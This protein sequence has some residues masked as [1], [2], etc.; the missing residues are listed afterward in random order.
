MH[1]SPESEGLQIVQIFPEFQESNSTSTS[2]SGLYV[3]ALPAAPARVSTEVWTT[4][5]MMFDGQIFAISAEYCASQH[6]NG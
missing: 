5:G 2:T 1:V 6:S 3:S 4:M